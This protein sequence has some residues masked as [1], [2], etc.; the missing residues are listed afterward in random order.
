MCLILISAGSFRHRHPRFEGAHV[1]NA[2][3]SGMSHCAFDSFHLISV[4]Q[5]DTYME[6]AVLA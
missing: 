4:R 1:S 6:H 3:C 5:G 2:V